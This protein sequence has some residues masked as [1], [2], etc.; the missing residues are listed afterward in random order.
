MSHREDVYPETG[1]RL[2]PLKREELATEGQA[3]FD[4]LTSPSG[5]TLRGLRGPGGI[6]LHS[7]AYA[8]LNR[9]VNRFFRSE[10]GLD[11]RVRE[12]AI[13]VTARCC[14]S[15]FEWAAHE[16][17]AIEVGVPTE[18]V[19]AIRR[20]RPADEAHPEDRLVI[21]L[22]RSIFLLRNVPAPLYRA[23]H[24][25]FGSAGLVNLV[26]LMG[27]FASTAA[28]LTT[29]DMQLDPGVEQPF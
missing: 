18:T 5:G 29:F 1:C 6:T 20:E 25:R 19:E 10:S 28:L 8:K 11:P 24:A 17:E 22:A 7:P 21:E 26:A 23:A 15:R 4:L 3:I 16:A 27:S 14:A 9:P 13:L 12:A 2:P